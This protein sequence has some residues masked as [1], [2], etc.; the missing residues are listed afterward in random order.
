VGSLK[1]LQD[2]HTV[3]KSP[4][5]RLRFLVYLVGLVYLVYLVGLVCLVYLVRGARRAG[6]CQVSDYLL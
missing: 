5:T 6:N 3:H 2:L 4:Q 1:L